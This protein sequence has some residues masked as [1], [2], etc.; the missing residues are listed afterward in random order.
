M[1]HRI[2]LVSLVATVLSLLCLGGPA[3]AQETDEDFPT[4]LERLGREMEARQL[5]FEKLG[6]TIGGIEPWPRPDPEL[7]F[8][9]WG[10]AVLAA[11]RVTAEQVLERSET[12]KL[13]VA[14][15][16]T[17]Q[18]LFEDQ[19]DLLGTVVE[20]VIAGGRHTDPDSEV[21]L[22]MTLLLGKVGYS[23]SRGGQSTGSEQ[24]HYLQITASLVLPARVLRAGAVRHVPLDLVN[25]IR[26]RMWPEKPGRADVKAEMTAAAKK[27]FDSVREKSTP[28]PAGPGVWGPWIGD[29]AQSNLRFDAWNEAFQERSWK[30][31]PALDAVPG[32]HE[33]LPWNEAYR[34]AWNRALAASGF[35]TGLLD[36]PDLRGELFFDPYTG[37]Q[38]LN[39][40]GILMARS[41]VVERDAVAVLGGRYVRVAGAS[42][43]DVTSP[44]FALENQVSRMTGEVQQIGIQE[45]LA[46]LG[47]GGDRAGQLRHQ[48][49]DLVA[50]Y[51]R[52]R[53]RVELPDE[54]VDGVANRIALALDRAVDIPDSWKT[55]WKAPA[56]RDPMYYL[57]S[58]GDARH[59]ELVPGNVQEAV[60]RVIDE[61]TLADPLGLYAFDQ[62]WHH[63][64]SR[65]KNELPE[66][67]VDLL[68]PPRPS[69]AGALERLYVDT[70]AS[71]AWD[72]AASY[73]QKDLFRT[74]QANLS[75]TFEG[76]RILVCS[77]IPGDGDVQWTTQRFFWYGTEPEGWDE[78][79]KTL[80]EKIRMDRIGPARKLPPKYV[81]EADELIARD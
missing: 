2:H 73:G 67:F 44:R 63:D 12:V 16:P 65:R 5:D 20:A 3:A 75:S 35:S 61:L 43:V 37:G 59:A 18:E 10:D 81:G 50:S 78:L 41:I 56:G 72:L 28:V 13:S 11:E 8:A 60:R 58:V 53:Q 70:A 26:T 25:T 32:F 17:V 14:R 51:L 52:T 62:P 15:N 68:S 6:A 64:R 7:A 9:V 30:L 46:E 36:A 27:L 42:F 22:Y 40:G 74:V 24:M 54:F 4:Q 69:G 1:S 80:P 23:F 21:K 77:Y 39:G 29:L 71:A 55:R 19:E 79:V 34:P 47:H 33:L 48:D 49:A 66:G 45:F 76:Q 38:R 57:A 31:D